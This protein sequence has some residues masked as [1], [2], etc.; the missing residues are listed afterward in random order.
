L[1]AEPDARTAPPAWVRAALAQLAAPAA[2]PDGEVPGDG[3]RRSRLLG[4]LERLHG[5][6]AW[7]ESA[8]CGEPLFQALPK[9][10]RVPLARRIL[11][12]HRRAFDLLI[13]DSCGAP[14]YVECAA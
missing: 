9:P 5:Q 2:E 7:E 12:R 14:G 1:S 6:G 13:L 11:R 4:L 10:R 8:P 3:D